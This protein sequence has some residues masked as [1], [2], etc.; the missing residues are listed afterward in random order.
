MKGEND[1]LVSRYGKATCKTE[2]SGKRTGGIGDILSGTIAAFLCRSSGVN[3]DCGLSSC[4]AACEI[5]RMA[6]KIAY[7]RYRWSVGA[8]N[9]LDCICNA[10]NAKFP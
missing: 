9:V 10:I 1:E 5:V 8:Q 7:D 2:G 3:S 4:M 6:S